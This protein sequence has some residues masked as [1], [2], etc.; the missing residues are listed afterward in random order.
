MRRQTIW[1]RWGRLAV[2]PGGRRSRT[3]SLALLRD[4][5]V[6]GRGRSPLK[7]EGDLVHV[8]PVPVLAWLIRSDQRM[9]HLAEVHGCVPSRRVVAAPD[10]PAL[11]AAAQVD[12][13]VAPL[14]QAVLTP[15]RGRRHVQDLIEVCAG[16]H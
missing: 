9:G 6:R 4:S 16:V 15:G 12:P 5:W 14:R 11:L 1:W 2:V 8:A 7:F 10:V 3:S 13:V